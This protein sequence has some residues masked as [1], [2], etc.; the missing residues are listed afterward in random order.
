MDTI[1]ESAKVKILEFVNGNPNSHL[2]KI[3]TNLGYSM[4]IV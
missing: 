4:C 3:K 2:R 1:I